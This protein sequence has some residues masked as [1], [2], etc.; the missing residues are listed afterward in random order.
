MGA[1]NAKRVYA[2]W[3]K[4]L[5]A[6]PLTVL[7]FMALTSL[8]NDSEPRFWQGHEVLAREVLGLDVPPKPDRHGAT[9][10]DIKAYDQ[11]MR[12][13]RR[14]ITPLIRKRAVIVVQHSA[15]GGT[16]R[17]ATNAIYRV[18]LDGPAPSPDEP[19]L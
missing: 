16:Y 7:V 11:V 12:R 6:K 19:A 10:K 18:Y 2:A 1:G 13:V 5:T 14:Q 15:P 8:D 3:S 4:E 9:E 17:D